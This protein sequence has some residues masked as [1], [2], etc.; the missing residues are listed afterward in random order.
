MCGENKSRRSRRKVSLGSPPH[1]RGKLP[2]AGTYPSEPGI[3]PACAGKTPWV[4]GST[5]LVKDHPRMCGENRLVL[6]L[7]RL[8]LGSPP[9]VRG[10][11]DKIGA[12]NFNSGITPACAG[13]TW[14]E[15]RCASFYGDHPRMCGEN[16][17]LKTK[18]LTNPGSPPHVRGKLLWRVLCNGSPRITPACAGKTDKFCLH[19]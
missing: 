15:C 3:T 19:Q 17:I 7:R 4:F 6:E 5:W 11:L 8:A 18:S 16:V 9:H 1:V 14:W 12:I 2:N 10:K 13:K